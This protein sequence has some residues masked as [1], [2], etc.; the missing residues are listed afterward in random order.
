MENGGHEVLIPASRVLSACSDRVILEYDQVCRDVS[1]AKKLY[2]FQ[3]KE[4]KPSVEEPGAT[5]YQE[6]PLLTGVTN[7]VDDT[8]AAPA[9][10]GTSKRVNK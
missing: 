4:H 1:H 9:Q 10:P 5:S 6:A 3:M 7:Q 2:M 8:H